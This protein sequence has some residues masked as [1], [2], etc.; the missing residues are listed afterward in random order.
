MKGYEE[1][2]AEDN[3]LMP[4][5]EKQKKRKSRLVPAVL[6]LLCAVTGFLS[7]KF[8]FKP[9]QTENEVHAVVE[10][11][12]DALKNKDVDTALT[13]TD[14]DKNMDFSEYVISSENITSSNIL[15]NVLIS[16]M[17]TDAA[18]KDVLSYGLSNSV[19]DYELKEI[20]VEGSD[21]VVRL[22]VKTPDFN[23]AV[24]LSGE[25]VLDIITNSYEIE[26]LTAIFTSIT[27]AAAARDPISIANAVKEILGPV[28]DQWPEQM[29]ADFDM[30]EIRSIDIELKL[31]RNDN[32][33]FI[34]S[35]EPIYF[36]ENYVSDVC[37]AILPE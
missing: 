7:Y 35:E 30:A 24:Q 4:V 26:N 20:H 36:I 13:Y 32:G 37:N 27:L 22:K 33:W 25:K 11:C 10:A 1:K 14:Y 12:L 18:W 2:T 23:A 21:A 6:L 8:Y 34:K 29:K 9:K 19:R 31:E 17:R 15:N 16:L 5:K 3:L 28:Y